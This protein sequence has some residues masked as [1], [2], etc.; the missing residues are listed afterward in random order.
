MSVLSRGILALRTT[1]VGVVQVDPKK[2]LE[3]GIRRELV[4]RV[5]RTLHSTFTF[6]SRS[7]DR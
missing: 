1:L 5:A 7:K 2:L 3:E 4:N 6:N